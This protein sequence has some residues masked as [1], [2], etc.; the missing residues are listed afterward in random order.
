M[1]GYWSRI[2]DAIL[3]KDADDNG[4]GLPD[5]FGEWGMSEAGAPVNSWSAMHHGPVMAAVSILAEDLAKIPVGVY[6]RRDDGGKE[7][8]TDHVL[9][10]LLKKPNDYQTGFEWKEMMQAAL[11]LR[12]NAYSVIV[13][14]GRGEP[15]SLVPIHPDRVM[16]WEAPNGDYFYLVTRNGLHEMAMLR[17]MPSL[18]PS[19]DILHL[20]WMQFFHSL[21]GSSRISLGREPIG[22]GMSLAEHHSRF[23][24]QGTRLAGYL[25][26]DKSLPDDARKDLKSA[27]EKN[28]AGPRSA[29][30]TAVLEYGL[31]WQQLGMSMVDAEFMAS[32]EFQL[33]EVAR[34]FGLPPYKLG[35]MGADSGP[36][37]VQQGQEYLN[38]P[39]SGYCERWKAS[40]ERQFDIDGDDTFIF[41]D[42]SHWLR[43]D[44]QTRFTAYRQS[45]GAPWMAV[46]EARRSEG[47]PE[48]EH[49]D[50]VL[51]PTNLAPLGW[52]PPEKPAGGASGSD[53]TGS[54]GQ[55]GDGDADKLPGEEP[56]PTN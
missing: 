8:A 1:A 10:K 6:R 55:G 51:Q 16:L 22:L 9:H 36:S 43:A 53:Q 54:P 45:V 14:N 41:W 42:Y 20:R 24:G 37:L 49:G 30:R 15:L 34:V 40:L 18:I 52:E 5:G 50:D 47:L 27:W 26:T 3:G 19:E 39:M 21:M 7:P 2:A 12:G 32:R 48:Q 44:I 11:V 56:A 25:S 38:G 31:K 13:R 23:A 17:S 35:I 33:R 28:Y 4:S 46:N 29:G